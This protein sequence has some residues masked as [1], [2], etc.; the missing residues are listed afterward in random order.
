MTIK[1][2]R[3]SAPEIIGTYLGWD[4]G[5]V[6]DMRYQPT[7]YSSPA[8]YNIEA[9]EFKY[10]CSPSGSQKL[11]NLA[12]EWNGTTKWSE[13]GEVYGRKIFGTKGGED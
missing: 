2:K 6:S 13:V 3:R 4:M 11:P 8:I 7:R 1:Q 12:K 10:L 5:D 9:G